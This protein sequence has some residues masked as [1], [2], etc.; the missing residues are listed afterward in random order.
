M[1]YFINSQGALPLEIDVL[2][3]KKEENFFKAAAFET[4]NRNEKNL[5]TIDEC[6]VFLNK[7]E[8]L[9]NSMEKPV[10]IYGIYFSANGFSNDVEKWLNDNGILTVDFETWEN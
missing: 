1:N 9:K 7:L 5:P 2:A 10:I 8:I 4:K 3:I 6:K